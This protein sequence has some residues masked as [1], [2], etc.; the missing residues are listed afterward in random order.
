MKHAQPA[1]LEL[2]MRTVFNLLGPLTNPA[3]ANAQLIGAPSNEAAEL[4]A[5]A[6]A[7][8]GGVSGYVV[9]GF[10]GLD[11]IST[12]GATLVFEVRGGVVQRHIWQP[13]DFGVK[14]AAMDE[15]RGGDRHAN[16]AILR[17]VLTG[18]P[19]P[20]RDIVLVNSAAA[21]MA[22]KRVSGPTDGM[23]IAADSIDSGRACA[24][25]DA[26]ILHSNS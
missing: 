7:G 18:E 3:R 24:K 23:A 14:R 13:V 19:G 10:D 6:M 26:L 20:R 15:L 1:R 5:E 21:L 2:K 17:S 11:E 4:M 12:T 16:A 8:L 9:H 22:A 25:L